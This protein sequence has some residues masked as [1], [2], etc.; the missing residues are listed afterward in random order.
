M[1]ADVVVIGA[2]ASGLAAGRSLA[3]AGVDVVVVEARDRIGGRI[4]TLRDD[5]EVVEAGAHVVH[6]ANASTWSVLAEGGISAEPLEHAGVVIRIDGRAYSAHELAAAGV[7]PPWSLEEFVVHAVR[8]DGSVADLFDALPL[9]SL[10]RRIGEDW[11]LQTWGAPAA[12]LAAAELAQARLASTAGD[13]QF[14]VAGGFDQV[15]TQ[16]AR[17]LDVRLGSTVRKVVARAA[18]VDLLVDGGERLR[19]RAAVVT[20]PPSVVAGGALVFEP[21]LPPGKLEAARALPLCDA[22]VLVLRLATPAAA[23]SWDFVVG[24]V[25]GFWQ[26][27]A[28]SR[29]LVGVFKGPP[30]ARVRDLVRAAPVP[31]SVASVL[32]APAAGAVEDVEIVDWGADPLAR[33]AFSYPGFSSGDAARAWAAPVAPTL[34]FAGEATCWERHRGLVNGAIESG[35]RCAAEVIGAVGGGRRLAVR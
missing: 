2:G 13:G 1:D 25:S 18:S 35:L 34:Y 4:R 26:A 15:A 20:V 12:D 7:M 5:D 24:A 19:A 9:G 33:G 8:T 6:G 32:P 22:L 16:L 21:A 31:A 10:E 11:L 3:A 23:S 29:T 17:G 28:D 27:R 30:A 14:V